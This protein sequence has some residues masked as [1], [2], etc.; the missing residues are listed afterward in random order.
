[1]RHV[2]KCKRYNHHTEYSRWGCR[3]LVFLLMLVLT[4][5][6]GITGCGGKTAGSTEN[7]DGSAAG[8]G[9]ETEV[10]DKKED[11]GAEDTKTEPGSNNPDADGTVDVTEENP[12]SGETN[13]DTAEQTGEEQPDSGTP[14][15]PDEVSGTPF[16]RY[17]KLSVS[18]TTLAD[19]KGNVVQ[20]IIT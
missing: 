16:E 5:T 1:M 9:Q 12:G 2:K 10:T 4:V 14:G 20:P 3:G 11:Q 17:G 7:T 15:R 8:I 13:T 18:G 19:Q 6:M